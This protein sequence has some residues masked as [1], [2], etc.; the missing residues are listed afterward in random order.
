MYDI[1]DAAWYCGVYGRIS[2]ISI[3]TVKGIII[4]IK[5]VRTSKDE[6]KFM[7]AIDKNSRIPLYAQ[8][9]DIIYENID[10][11]A[12]KEDDKLPSERELCSLYDISRATVR[13]AMNVL[14]KEGCIYKLHGKGVYIS[15]K[16][17]N[18]DLSKFYSFSEEMKKLGRKPTSKVIEFEIICSSYK[19]SSKLSIQAGDEVYE[20]KRLRLADEKAIMIETTYIPCYRFPGLKKSELE[21]HAMYEV[22]KNKYNAELT[23]AEEIFSPT[24]ANDYEANIL[25]IDKNA[26]A[27]IIER[28]TYEREKVIEYTF[29]VV[30]GDKFKYRVVLK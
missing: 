20:I 27:M 13:Q 9:I 22:L 12:L 30:R 5:V 14:E 28:L 4:R 3:L 16:K 24:I 23:M 6:E 15:P 11:K 25:E 7:K 26:P 1:I 8:L 17:L 19:I 2:C 21:E 10:S 18:Q 29:G